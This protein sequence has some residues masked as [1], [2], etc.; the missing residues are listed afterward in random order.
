MK[1]ITEAVLISMAFVGVSSYA[2][3]SD[4]EEGEKI[5]L[6]VG[7]GLPEQHGIWQGDAIS[8]MDKV[9][10]LTDGQVEF[11][12]FT[13]GEL[14][15]AGE[16]IE[17]VLNGIIDIGLFLPSYSPAEFPMADVTMLP[18]GG[19][20]T[21]VYSKAYRRLMTEDV[22]L[23]GQGSFYD[24]MY[25]KNG[26]KA[27]PIDTL[28][29]YLI[30][31][32]GASPESVSALRGLSLRT[33]SRVME[34]YAANAGMSSITMPAVEMFDA[35]SR[36]AFDGSFITIPDWTAY[37]FQD[38]F[39]YTL[40]DISFGTFHGSLGM[41][42]ETWEGLPENVQ[43]A[44]TTAI[45]ETAG[46]GSDLWVSREEDVVKEYEANGGKFQSFNDLPTDVQEE[47]LA[48]AEETWVDFIDLLEER[49]LPGREVALYWRD[50]ILNEGGKVPEGIE[51]L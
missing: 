47:M 14:V 8:W 6:R 24:I 22:D 48:A 40:T 16:E 3:P 17:A 25:E 4:A 27:F 20:D 51:D 23:G 42:T 18:T 37:G 35:L 36:G 50:L 11:K 45:E 9:E 12:T 34:L 44:M 21:Y 13:S 32:T 49:G 39:T 33:P 1:R 7:T 28:Q 29:G 38:L 46:S 31:T 5:T 19:A 41:T 2:N 30:S 26:L 10:E 15:N 43:E